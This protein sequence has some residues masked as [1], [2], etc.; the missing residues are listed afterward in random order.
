MSRFAALGY[1]PI[2]LEYT[3]RHP[4]LR[5][6]ARPLTE[7]GRSSLVSLFAYILIPYTQLGRT[8]FANTSHYSLPVG[9]LGWSLKRADDVT[10]VFA[11]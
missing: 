11:S 3:I 8:F 5:P 9:M 1:A 4:D 10:N 7:E 2:D 6:S